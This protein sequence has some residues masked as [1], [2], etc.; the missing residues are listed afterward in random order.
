MDIPRVRFGLEPNLASLQ[1]HFVTEFPN[2]AL[3]RQQILRHRF[4]YWRGLRFWLTQFEMRELNMC[5][6]PVDCD[7]SYSRHSS[8]GMPRDL[9]G[10]FGPGNGEH[11]NTNAQ[12]G[13]Q[14]GEACLRFFGY[15]V[16]NQTICTFHRA[17]ID[18]PNSKADELSLM[19]FERENWR[20]EKNVVRVRILIGGTREAPG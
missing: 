7:K 13:G 1:H 6:A 18:V 9:G 19:W 10:D 8:L 16:K 2:L 11:G 20:I 4:A 3:P 14:A 17:F 15:L 5:G 12:N